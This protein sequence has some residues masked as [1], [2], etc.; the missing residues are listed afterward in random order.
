MINEYLFTKINTPITVLGKKTACFTRK[1]ESKNNPAAQTVKICKP[2][3]ANVLNN[4][5]ND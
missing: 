2:K 1:Q 5:K 4:K 3:G